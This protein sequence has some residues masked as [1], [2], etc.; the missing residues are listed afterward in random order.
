MSI[1]TWKDVSMQP[2]CVYVVGEFGN[3]SWGS[4]E[5]LYSVNNDRVYSGLIVSDRLKEGWKITKI[6]TGIRVGELLLIME[7]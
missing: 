7:F 3:W 5:K 1:V 4:S 6:K 2:D